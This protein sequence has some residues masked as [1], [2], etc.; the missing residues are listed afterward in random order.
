MHLQA[1]Q[2]DKMITNAENLEY[3]AKQEPSHLSPLK[4]ELA[5]HLLEFLIITLTYE[6]VKAEKE[7]EY[8]KNEV[9]LV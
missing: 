2:I 8:K 1:E 3:S 7:I 6:K 9:R 4:S 5:K